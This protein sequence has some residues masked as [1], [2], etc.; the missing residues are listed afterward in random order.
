MGNHITRRQLLV[1]AG[2][3]IGTAAAFGAMPLEAS[4]A[5]DRERRGVEGSWYVSVHITSPAGLPDFDVVYGFAKGGVFTR[6]DGRANFPNVPAIGTWKPGEDGGIVFSN[7]LFNFSGSPPTRNGAIVGN[8]A[9]R[10]TAEDKLVGTF[11][12]HGVLGLNGFS[13]AGTFSGTRIEAVG[14]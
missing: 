4:A 12:A 8:F 6:I 5:A 3:A 10:V 11:T 14:P 2:G 13:R 7:I 9:A 1:G